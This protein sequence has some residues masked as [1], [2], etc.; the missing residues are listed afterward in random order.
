MGRAGVEGRGGAGSDELGFGAILLGAGEAPGLRG[1]ASSGR[2]TALVRSARGFLLLLLAPLFPSASIAAT[3]WRASSASHR[4][5]AEHEWRE[6]PV[7][8]E[9]SLLL[10][11]FPPFSGLSETTGNE[12]KG[13]SGGRREAF[14]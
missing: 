6:I 3:R 1:G 10:L 8:M 2:E 14:C 7:E 9:F 11:S 4:A 12:S 5:R 13:R